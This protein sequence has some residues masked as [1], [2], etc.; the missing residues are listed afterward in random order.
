MIYVQ[1]EDLGRIDIC[2]LEQID[3]DYIRRLLESKSDETDNPDIK[4]RSCGLAA[5][6]EPETDY[7]MVWADVFLISS[8]LLNESIE[9]SAP[10]IKWQADRLLVCFEAAAQNIIESTGQGK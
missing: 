1:D 7:G 6:L 4:A 5:G 9:A 2:E 3:V 8:L 10:A